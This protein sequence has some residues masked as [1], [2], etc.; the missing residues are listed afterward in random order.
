[1]QLYIPQ[2]QYKVHVF[3]GYHYDYRENGLRAAVVWQDYHGNPPDCYIENST[4]NPMTGDNVTFN[5]TII[6]EYGKNL[7][8][9]PIPLEFIHTDVDKPQ[10][11][12]K[13]NGIDGVCPAFNCGYLY[14]D[15]TGQITAQTVS[16][17]S[18]TVT[19]TSLPTANV[20]VAVANS[21]CG[22]VTASS[23]EITC[24]LN[25]GAAAGSWDI[26][27]SDLN[28]YTPKESTVA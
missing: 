11:G 8:F 21:V 1:M 14:G 16:G 4:E 20:T 18:V 24:T 23:T 10:V 3:N 19:G 13:V 26:K 9:E 17:S 12:I 2:A 27:V 28:G 7:M 22:T 25:A 15:P 6:R 5:T